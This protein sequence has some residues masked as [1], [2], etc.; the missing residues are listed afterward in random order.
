M[1]VPLEPLL[2]NPRLKKP[3][4]QTTTLD[5][6][7]RIAKKKEKT[8]IAN[9]L[10]TRS[11]I[12]QQHVLDAIYA[13]ASEFTM[14]R[15][16]MSGVKI[17]KISLKNHSPPTNMANRATDSK[18]WT[19]PGLYLLS[20]THLSLIISYSLINIF[21]FYIDLCVFFSMIIALPKIVVFFSSDHPII[22]HSYL[23]I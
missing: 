14:Q 9:A 3:P 10:I 11:S 23:S 19:L 16:S 5:F 17:I 2:S 7:V 8:L 22:T 1:E 18:K 6:C 21:L 12:W 15:D 20:I 4:M 13:C